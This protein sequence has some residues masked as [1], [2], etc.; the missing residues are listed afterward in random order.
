V[1]DEMT[2]YMI[3]LKGNN[4]SSIDVWNTAQPYFGKKV[5]FLYSNTSFMQ[6]ISST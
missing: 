6:V 5:A 2:S 3:E 4:L 1:A